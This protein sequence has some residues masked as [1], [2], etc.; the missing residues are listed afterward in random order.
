MGKEKPK[1]AKNVPVNEKR[2]KVKLKRNK[3]LI[4][5]GE[6]DF[7]TWAQ[8]HDPLFKV[9]GKKRREQL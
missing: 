4:A 6:A 8:A 5:M 2:G 1:V 7:D 3:G 9:K